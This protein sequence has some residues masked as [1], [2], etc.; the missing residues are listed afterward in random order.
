MIRPNEAPGLTAALARSIDQR[1]TDLAALL[2]NDNYRAELERANL[3]HRGT[4][5][6]ATLVG[7]HLRDAARWLAAIANALAE[8]AEPARVEFEEC[9]NCRWKW[10]RGQ[11]ETHSPKCTASL[12]AGIATPAPQ[13]E[14]ELRALDVD[15]E[16]ARALNE[17]L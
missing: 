17:G 7:Q 2:N 9:P 4:L 16:A 11:P 15:V 6:L 10:R 1:A 12:L 13:S 5:L 14:A 8:P 3:A